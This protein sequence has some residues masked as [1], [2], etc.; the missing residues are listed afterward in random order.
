MASRPRPRLAALLAAGATA[1]AALTASAAGTAGPA[2]AAGSVGSGSLSVI[3]QAQPGHRQEAAVAVRAAGGQTGRDLSIVEGFSARL[4]EAALRRLAADPSIRQIT[5][6]GHVRFSMQ[7]LGA[8]DFADTGGQSDVTGTESMTSGESPPA[9][10]GDDTVASNYPKSTGA[11]SAW[12]QG[13][14][15]AGVTVALIDTGVSAVPDLAGRVIAGPDFSGERNSLRDSYGH[16]TVMAGI[17]AGDGSSSAGVP[18]GA[19]VGMAPAATVV[20]VKA[21]GRNGA[22]DVSTVLAAMQWVGSHQAQYDIRVVNLSWGTRSDQ[23]PSVDPLNYA[24]ERLWAYGIVVVAAAGNDG[25]SSRTITKPGDD[26]VIITAGAYDDRQNT[27]PD[28]DFVTAWSSRG[29][30][31]AGAAKPDVIAPGRTLVATRSPGSYI[32]DNNPQALV[33]SGYIRGSGTSQ[34]SAVV[35]GSV[36]LLLGRRGSLRPDQ[37]KH[38]LT[39]RAV[40]MSNSSAFGHGRV[41]VPGMSQARVR[42]APVQSLPSSGL[43]SLEA[44]RGGRHVETVC[45]GDSAPTSIEGEIDALC[46]PWDGEA[47][48]GEAWTSASWSR[49]NWSGE[50]W[51]GESWSGESWSGESWTGTE[52]QTA[53][54]G[55]QTPWWQQLPGETSAPR[56]ADSPAMPGSN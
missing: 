34:S 55:Y 44:S 48:T 8:E 29:P 7:P 50:S 28:D 41:S 27:A 24:V 32:E 26:P 53:F 22:T 4:P 47:W 56:T 9:D 49:Q 21:A 1:A 52:F 40:P 37:V 30:T 23:S 43:G 19:Y 10:G 51:S 20:S 14:R 33:G 54:W 12:R 16:G 5:P 18:G 2:T 3:V 42:S 36:A 31:A 35:S 38:A 17:I 15:G 39:S 13:Q 25:P 6:N 45:D 11:V 46:Q